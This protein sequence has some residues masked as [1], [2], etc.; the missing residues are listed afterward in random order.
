MKNSRK[1]VDPDRELK[2]SHRNLLLSLSQS[3]DL[4]RATETCCCWR[5][6]PE[7]W[8]THAVL[9]IRICLSGSGYLYLFYW[10]VSSHW[11]LLLLASQT[12]RL[13]DSCS[14]ED[15]DPGSSTPYLY[16]CYWPVSNHWD[17]LLLASQTSRLVDSCSVAD[18]DPGSPTPY[19]LKL[20]EKFLGNYRSE[21]IRTGTLKKSQI[22]NPLLS[23][24]FLQTCVEP[25]RL[26]VVGVPD[27]KVGGLM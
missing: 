21:L 7:G 10:P 13:A 24:S 12:R 1:C 14:V 2:K 25:L 27:Q 3:T 8:R 20:N 6:R 18:P 4:C 15:S 16:L 22:R 26:A 19:F 11:D 17:L 5:P 23:L 9:R